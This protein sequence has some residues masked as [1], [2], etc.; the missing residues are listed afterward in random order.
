MGFNEIKKSIKVQD[1]VKDK[2][3]VVL[4]FDFSDI[5]DTKLE[6]KKRIYNGLEELRAISGMS[7]PDICF[8]LL[9]EALNAFFNNKARK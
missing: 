7:K 6:M 1:E 9:D 5:A 8:E 2:V 4:R 3:S